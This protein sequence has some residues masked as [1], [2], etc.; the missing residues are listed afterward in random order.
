MPYCSGVCKRYKYNRKHDEKWYVTGVKRC[1]F[2]NIF[3]KINNRECP[4]CKTTL[5]TQGRGS[6]VKLGRT[7]KRM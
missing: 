4:C 6:D 5:R 3:M 1:N 2:C 7:L